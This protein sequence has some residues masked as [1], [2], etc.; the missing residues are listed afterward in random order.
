MKVIITDVNRRDGLLVGAQKDD[1]VCLFGY[2]LQAKTDPGIVDGE[3]QQE[4]R[5]LGTDDRFL[6]NE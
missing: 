4:F 1:V 2:Y 3:V 6:Y 5:Y